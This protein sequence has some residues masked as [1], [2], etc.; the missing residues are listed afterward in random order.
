MKALVIAGVLAAPAWASADRPV[1]GSAGAGAAFLWTGAD[2]DRYRYELELD[3]EPRSRFGGLVAWRGFD[4]DHHGMLLAGLVYEAGAARPTLVVDLHADVGADL[5]Q[6]APVFGGGIRTTLTI[7]GPFGVALD[8]GAYL[9]ID[10]VDN[11]RLAIASSTSA[12]VRW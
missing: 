2:G 6:R 9:V 12:V 8:G 4:A 5:D 11:T 1:H 10:G 3:L 7:W